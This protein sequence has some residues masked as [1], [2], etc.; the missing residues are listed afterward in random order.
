M[1]ILDVFRTTIK[2]GNIEIDAYTAHELDSRGNWIN[3]LSGKGMAESI[4]LPRN[5]TLPK[6][7]SESLKTRLGK[8]F[9]TLH[10]RYKMD[11]GGVSKAKMWTTPNAGIYY[12]YHAEQ[13]NQK[14]LKIVIGLASA[15]L[16]IIIN[17]QFQ[18]PYTSGQTQQ[19]ANSR[20]L[21]E[22]RVWERLYSDAIHITAVKWF[23]PNFYWDYCY[24]FLSAEEVCKLNL[25]NPIVN[26]E[27]NFRIHQYLDESV[28]IELEKHLI[29]V[30]DL[31]DSS[32][33]KQDFET[34]YQKI[35]SRYF[36][37]DLAM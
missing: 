22:P 37:L 23:G 10:G 24:C 16:D 5:S 29:R 13:G 4:G 28:R 25:V 2:L 15:A 14:A 7:F 19:I 18:R 11:S 9:T 33:G 26:G 6:R 31:V 1:D 8:E 12:G 30:I 36:Q 35:F 21:D 20:I 32:T 27:R 3:Y 34:R 17:D